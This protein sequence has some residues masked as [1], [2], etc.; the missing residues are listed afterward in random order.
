MFTESQR[1]H[2]QQSLA[3]IEQTL[4]DALLLAARSR[5]DEVFP[6]YR[7]ALP[8]ADTAALQAALQRLRG[9]LRRFAHAHGQTLPAAGA[10][11][12]AWALDT[13]IT[14]LRN[15]ALELRP[16]HLAGYGAL[17]EGA[18]MACRALAAEVGAVL[19]GMQDA[20]RSVGGLPAPAA[21][22]AL[23]ALLLELIPRYRLGE[24]RARVAAL[25]ETGGRVEVAVLGRVSSGKSSLLNALIGRELLPV[26]IVPVTTVTTRL[27]GG[28]ASM[29]ELV[30]LDGRSEQRPLAEL[31]AAVDERRNP[32]NRRRLR[33]VRVGLGTPPWAA[34]VVFT[35]TPGLGA[36]EGEASAM[37][38]DYLPRCDLGLVLVDAGA[39]A[40][41]LE[42]DLLQALH[43]S[44][45]AL[46]V[47]LAKADLLGAEALSQQQAH[48]AASL[49]GAIGAVVP[50]DVLSSQPAW[51][52][53]REHWRESTLRPLLDA[54]RDASA[55]R[56]VQRAH[57]LGRQVLASLRLAAH[58]DAA[59]P[60][61][62]DSTAQLVLD[63][64]L[65]EQHRHIARYAEQAG[66]ALLRHAVEQEH[67]AQAC[68][69]QAG[70]LAHRLAQQTR[71][72]VSASAAAEAGALP[73]FA[74]PC[75]FLPQ[76]PALLPRPLRRTWR[77]H[78][79]RQERRAD[80]QAACRAYAAALHTWLD[81]AGQA[82][83][84]QLRAGQSAGAGDA[85]QLQR[86]IVRLARALG[87]ADPPAP[88]P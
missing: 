9:V 41:A 19:E 86:D 87:Q 51:Q 29:L 25:A 33:E 31:A 44:G 23:T 59:G 12:P 72:A 3:H 42:R 55:T 56:A 81:T 39:T 8:A 70:D 82:A 76:A 65:Q 45:A 63:Q 14:L 18:V 28:V 1:R 71:A 83:Q 10:I 62:F 74:W 73:A 84:R 67:D 17:D 38:M 32:G 88:P 48:V 57:V 37:A 36:L 52:A 20:L 53:A 47:V 5:H 13:Q 49:G 60:A 58:G 21:A 15:V 77:L 40:T 11:D 69:H 61:A 66:D 7:A 22:D 75:G 43:E 2:I 78:R 24:Y 50:V 16:A 54:L 4:G 68:A 46:R 34:G 35:D 79:L 85:Q 64:A 30:Y 80:L 27:I 6:R 26:G